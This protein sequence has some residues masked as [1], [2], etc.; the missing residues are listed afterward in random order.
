MTVQDKRDFIIG[1]LA[2]AG[3]S[4]S[5]TDQHF[6]ERWHARFGGTR[7][8]TL[9]GAQPVRNAMHHLRM[10]HREGLLRRS[11]VALGW[12]WQ[13]GFPKWVYVYTTLD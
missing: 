13:P 10:M 3:A 9:F 1:Y 6:H 12:N 5:A 8:E 11:K 2:E 4:A 7:K